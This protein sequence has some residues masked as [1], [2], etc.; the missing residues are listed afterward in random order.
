MV[1]E[2]TKCGTEALSE[3]DQA[4]VLDVRMARE[5]A[6]FVAERALLFDD[7]DSRAWALTDF[8]V[9]AVLA[10]RTPTLSLGPVLP[11]DD[12]DESAF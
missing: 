11:P 3:E 6:E 4:L 10:G 7:V 5:I 12:D 1:S 8:G 2:K 9:W